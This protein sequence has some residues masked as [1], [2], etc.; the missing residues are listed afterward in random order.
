MN[1]LAPIL[2]AFFTDRL[3]HQ[4]NA[5]PHTIAAY[6]D[7]MRLLLTFALKRT[8]KQPYN[9]D[10]SD[11]DAPLIGAFLEHL[12]RERSNTVRTRNARLA[13]IHSLFRFAALD[14]PED[15]ELI[16]RVLAIPPKCSDR[17]LVTHLTEPEV[18]ALLTAPDRATWTGRRDHA[19]L[20][21]AIQTGLRAS[22]L[23][24]LRCDDVHL[25]TG[26]H[27]SQARDFFQR[28]SSA[29]CRPAGAQ[30]PVPSPPNARDLVWRNPDEVIQDDVYLLRGSRVYRISDVR[31]Q[32]PRVSPRS[33]EQR[34]GLSIVNNLACALPEANCRTGRP[35]R[36]RRS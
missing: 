27:I 22:E 6:R 21:L 11:L 23:T 26:A 35:L 32:N 3:L 25:G 5:S 1:T 15:A 13:A 9:L 16:Q 30:I 8:G 4:R 31:P 34:I 20:L 12:E 33:T 14:H 36:H 18:D 19:L 2:Q 10:L 29:H 28:A 7:T 17:A 24:G